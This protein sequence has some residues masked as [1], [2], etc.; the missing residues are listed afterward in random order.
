MIGLT[1]VF[2][3]SLMGF[4]IVYDLFLELIS[5]VSSFSSI[6]TVNLT[7]FCPSRDIGMLII[8][9]AYITCSEHQ[10][11]ASTTLSVHPSRTRISDVC[12]LR[13]SDLNGR[14]SLTYAVV[15]GNH[16]SCFFAFPS[17]ELY[18]TKRPSHWSNSVVLITYWVLT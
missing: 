11:Y 8:K 18:S 16:N 10:E 3:F 14:C 13:V 4:W 9:E 12:L 7:A 2:Q 1:M 15:P 17:V 5:A 6:S